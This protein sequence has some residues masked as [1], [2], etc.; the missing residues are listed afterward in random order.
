[1]R[2]T[3]DD[4]TRPGVQVSEVRHGVNGPLDPLSR[5][6]RPQVS[7]TGRPERSGRYWGSAMAA[8]WG[9]VVTFEALTSKRLHNRC[10][11]VCAMTT[12]ALAASL[13]ASSTC[14]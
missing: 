3:G 13:M 14:L 8:P 10:R 11:A 9:I 12:T 4:V 7:N 5:P 6:S 1:M 2:A